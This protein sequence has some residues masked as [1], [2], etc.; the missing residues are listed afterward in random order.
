MKQVGSNLYYKLL[1]GVI[2]SSLLTSTLQKYDPAVSIRTLTNSIYLIS[3]Y[4]WQSTLIVITFSA[5]SNIS[6]TIY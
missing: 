5:T 1:V 2:G 3:L 6:T 4:S